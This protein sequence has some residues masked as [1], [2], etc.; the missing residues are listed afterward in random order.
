MSRTQIEQTYFEGPGDTHVIDTALKLLKPSRSF[1][2]TYMKTTES[3][4]VLKPIHELQPQDKLENDGDSHSFPFWYKL[5]S[6][7][8]KT[9]GYT[10]TNP[11][12]TSTSFSN[13]SSNIMDFEI[14][15]KLKDKSI[16]SMNN[17]VD[18]TSR[19][20]IYEESISLCNNPE[21]MYYWG[22]I[23]LFGIENSNVKCG[24]SSIEKDKNRNSVPLL[25]FGHTNTK[26]TKS[27]SLGLSIEEYDEARG[28]LALWISLENGYMNALMPLYMSLMTGK[29]IISILQISSI[30]RDTASDFD[31]YDYWDIPKPASITSAAN[32]SRLLQ[33]LSSFLVRN[34]HACSLYN[35]NGNTNDNTSQQQSDSRK[36]NFMYEESKRAYS[37]VLC[38]N[39]SSLSSK[40]S[41]N[42]P[43]TELALGLLHIAALF[44]SPEAY[45]ALT[46]RYNH[47]LGVTK[48]AET[49]CY[50]GVFAG[51]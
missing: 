27:A 3:G 48:D 45:T 1:I 22:M 46:Y 14:C 5:W 24:Y 12:T 11:T 49:A 9:T 32:P 23:H 10:T 18:I 16:D 47:G 31:I 30:H 50:Y 7:F 35:N 44:R 33:Q 17:C 13:P 19:I 6:P 40:P 34:I 28:V 25:E 15:Q 41:N 20:D 42:D 43:I 37:S 51:L 4:E 39:W 2:S 8:S 26:R 38:R 36:G 21:S 29:G